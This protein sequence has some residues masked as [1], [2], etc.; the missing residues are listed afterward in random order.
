MRY[1]LPLAAVT[2]ALSSTAIAED[3]VRKPMMISEAKLPEGFPGP[4]PIPPTAWPASAPAALATT[5]RS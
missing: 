4:G 3:A 2:L 1:V 5:A